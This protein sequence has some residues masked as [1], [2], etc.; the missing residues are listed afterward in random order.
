MLSSIIFRARF[1]FL[2]LELAEQQ[3]KGVE[4]WPSTQEGARDGAGLPNGP[5]RGAGCMGGRREGAR[6]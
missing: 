4:K 2:L 5:V 6:C 3:V 1:G